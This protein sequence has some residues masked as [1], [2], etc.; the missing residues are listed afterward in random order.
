MAARVLLTVYLHALPVLVPVPETDRHIIRTRENIWESGMD[1]NAT[2][3]IAV[4][5]PAVNLLV[6][7]VV[8][9][10]KLHVV[11]S[12]NH[13]VLASNE[14]GGTNYFLVENTIKK[15]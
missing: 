4:G 14:L 13:I 1:S 15:H 7:V 10:T 12:S 3:V 9:D 11:R 5:I 8:E 2:N 6:S